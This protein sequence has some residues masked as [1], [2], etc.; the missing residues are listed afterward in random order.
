MGTGREETALTQVKQNE[1]SW[2]GENMIMEAGS[3]GKVRNE[4]GINQDK[5]RLWLPPPSFTPP[6]FLSFSPAPFV[7]VLT[8]ACSLVND[9]FDP[10][11]FVVQVAPPPLSRVPQSLSLLRVILCFLFPL[12]PSSSPLACISCGES[13]LI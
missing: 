12:S 13:C 3:T 1:D 2:S 10:T 11:I 6:L 7:D 5:R 8:Y 4:G 9:V